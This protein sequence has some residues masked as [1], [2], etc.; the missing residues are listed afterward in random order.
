[1]LYVIIQNNLKPA[2]NIKE[3]LAV[4]SDIYKIVNIYRHGGGTISP[5]SWLG[6]FG[7]LLMG[8]SRFT[9][10]VFLLVLV[11]KIR[12]FQVFLHLALDL[13]RRPR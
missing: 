4:G 3:A 8:F 2:L 12:W 6:G 5:F 13:Q 7:T 10:V 1:M 11:T 9:L